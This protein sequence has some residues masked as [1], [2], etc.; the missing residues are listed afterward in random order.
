[1]WPIF[2]LGV[3][4][5]W[6]HFPLKSLMWTS[7]PEQPK[8]R[9]ETNIP[10]HLSDTCHPEISQQVGEA[11]TITSGGL[12]F[13][14]R[15]WFT[16]PQSNEEDDVWGRA[17][18]CWSFG[19]PVGCCRKTHPSWG[20][21]QGCL[22]SVLNPRV[23]KWETMN[24]KE[25]TVKEAKKD[26]PNVLSTSSQQVRVFIANVISLRWIYL[27]SCPSILWWKWIRYSGGT[28]VAPETQ[29]SVAGKDCSRR[30]LH[31]VREYKSVT[32]KSVDHPKIIYK[33]SKCAR[34]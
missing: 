2:T 3:S 21:L 11:V 17:S 16:H 5:I 32:L 33:H 1:M 4:R 15:E 27:P 24:S 12:L 10:A 22:T 13:F 18:L 30:N 19:H 14:K 20:H 26:F 25:L 8:N 28:A 34:G 9:H 7:T 6:R 29:E 23:K 31:I